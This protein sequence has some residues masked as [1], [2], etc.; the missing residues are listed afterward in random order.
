MRKGS[1]IL[2]K[3]SS[4]FLQNFSCITFKYKPEDESILCLFIRVMKNHTSGKWWEPSKE[5]HRTCTAIHLH[6]LVIENM[7]LGANGILNR[8]MCPHGIVKHIHGR[9]KSHRRPRPAITWWSIPGKHPLVSWQ[10]VKPL[11]RDDEGKHI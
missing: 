5:K 6:A 2:L 11:I 4:V 10:V 3:N 8:H 7:G 9:P 1:Y